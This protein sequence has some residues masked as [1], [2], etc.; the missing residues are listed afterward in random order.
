MFM[1]LNILNVVKFDM[2][3]INWLARFIILCNVD[4]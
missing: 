2:F 1:I 3:Y 4:N